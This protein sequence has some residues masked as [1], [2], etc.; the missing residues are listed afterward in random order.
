MSHT[1]GGNR[2]KIFNTPSSFFE[3]ECIYWN[4]C[5]FWHPHKPKL[6][7]VWN[8][9]HSLKIMFP[10]EFKIFTLLITWW[11]IS[12][13]QCV[14]QCKLTFSLNYLEAIGMSDRK[15]R[16]PLLNILSKEPPNYTCLIGYGSWTCVAFIT[17]TL[18]WIWSCIHNN[19]HGWTLTLGSVIVWSAPKGVP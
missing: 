9:P 13:A 15:T 18:I 19:T 12:Y 17:T 10:M 2:W 1:K 5:P 11:H 3:Y 16:K 4:S 6:F 7:C 14:V 8:L